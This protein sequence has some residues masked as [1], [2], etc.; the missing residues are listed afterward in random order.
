[1]Q[2]INRA[3]ILGRSSKLNVGE[4]YVDAKKVAMD[5]NMRI[6]SRKL[7]AAILATKKVYRKLSWKE[8]KEARDYAEGKYE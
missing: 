6:G 4:S 2:N 7:L 1:M 8:L 3:P 5:Q